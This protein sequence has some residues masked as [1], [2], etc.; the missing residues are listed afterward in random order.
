MPFSVR[1]SAS[2]SALAASVSRSVDEKAYIAYGGDVQGLVSDSTA[3]PPRF[4]YPVTTLAYA[5]AST[6]LVRSLTVAGWPAA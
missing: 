3:P 4:P 2:A 6:T 5:T 1:D